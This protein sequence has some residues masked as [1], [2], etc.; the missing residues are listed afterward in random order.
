[1]SKGESIGQSP[2]SLSPAERLRAIQRVLAGLSVE[3][4][5]AALVADAPRKLCL[6][7]GLDRAMLTS[8]HDGK[9]AYASAAHPANPGYELRFPKLARTTRVSLV[10]LPPELQAVNE[11]RP[12]LVDDP[13]HRHG[14][15]RPLVVETRTSGYIVAPV[16]QGDQALGLLHADRLGGAP[17]DEFDA[18]LLGVFAMGLGSAMR[19]VALPVSNGGVVDGFAQV[20]RD[21]AAVPGGWAWRPTAGAL[22]ELTARER[23]VLDLLAVGASNQAIA[24]TLFVSEPTIKSHVRGVLRKLDAANRTEAVARYHALIGGEA[25]S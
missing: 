12:I 11:R 20:V 5:L 23:E 4:S 18:E 8:L 17:L 7:C 9:L 25:G 13:Q 1:M 10:E 22:A 14:V 15:F 3:P 21:G 16:L 6:E 24:G 19:G 2:T